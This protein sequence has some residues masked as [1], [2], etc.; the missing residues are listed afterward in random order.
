MKQ[1]A[2]IDV[3]CK[4]GLQTLAGEIG[5][6]L[7]QMLSCSD[8]KLR[9]C[10]KEQLFSNPARPKTALTRMSVTGEHEGN[11][12]LLNPIS[13]AAVLAGTLIM[14]PKDMIEENVKSGKLDG[15]LTDAFGEVANIIA[16]VMTQAFVDKYPKT[17]R[18]VK[19]TVEELIPTKINMDSDIPFPPGDYYVASCELT[20]DETDLGVFEFVV[21]LPI[22][23]LEETTPDTA[24]KAAPQEESAQKT[25]AA[26]VKTP[27][28]APPSAPSTAETLSAPPAPETPPA[29]KKPNFIDAKKLVDV[30]FKTTIGQIGEEIGALL[31]QTLK[32]SDIQLVMTTKEELFSTHCV[33]K[34]ILTQMKVSGDKNG[35]GYL[36]T[37]IPDAIAMGGTLIMLPDDQIAEQMGKGEFDGEVSDAFGEIANILAGSLTQVF[38]DRYPQQLR[39]V[40]TESQTIVPT[41]I[42]PSSD[43]PFAEDSYYLASFAIAMDGYELNRLLLL[44]PAELFDVDA[45]AEVAAGS[46]AQPQPAPA[47]T[48]SDIPASGQWGG[49]PVDPKSAGTPATGAAGDTIADGPPIVL[50]L[51]DQQ[52]AAEP[53]VKILTSASYDCRVVSFQDDI[54]GLLQQHQVLGIFLVMAQVG[55]KGFAAAIKLQSAGRTLPPLIFA[56]EEWTRSAVLRAVKYGA[57]DILV[58]PA[59]TDEIQDKVTQHFKKAS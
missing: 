1:R 20:I 21:P 54:K 3:V 58:I 56:G 9:T 49:P 53:F 2:L 43:Q 31:G 41:K 42:D 48:A 30:V 32:C 24:A 12:F 57:R 37:Q 18:F 45:P 34:A 22:F 10:S 15:E 19:K 13:A 16:G 51:S 36:L 28:E 52:S 38:L 14:L 7:G 11:C 40:R 5:A 25:G 23:D 6:L 44:F 8:I 39:F 29:V 55:E 59:S 50:I 17:L 33:D 27:A 26:T 35:V 46:Q 4:A 47:A